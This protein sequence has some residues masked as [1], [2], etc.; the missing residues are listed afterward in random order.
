MIAGVSA[1]RT[2]ALHRNRAAVQVVR[3]EHAP[4]DFAD[5][6][7]DALRGHRRRVAAR[8]RAF[9]EAR[10]KA[11]FLAHDCHVRNIHTDIFRRVIFPREALHGAAEGPEQFWRLAGSR[12]A[13]DHGLAAAQRNARHRIL[14]AHALRQPEHIG[15]HRVTGRVIPHPAAARRRPQRGRMHGNHAFQAGRRIVKS[16]HAL[17]A[18]KR[19][20]IEHRRDS[21]PVANETI[22][23]ALALTLPERQPR[24]SPGQSIDTFAGFPP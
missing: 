14:V 2:D 21:N 4:G 23:A 13:P 9:V 15:Q 3:P 1:D 6:E 5:A 7:I 11:R 12:I 16:V 17:M 8:C 24:P 10:H 18:V 20:V 19:G 22:C